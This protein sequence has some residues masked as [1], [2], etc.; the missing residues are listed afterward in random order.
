[1]SKSEEVLDQEGSDDVHQLSYKLLNLMDKEGYNAQIGLSGLTLTLIV[2]AKAI[3]IKKE[4]LLKA[5]QLTTDD[6]YGAGSRDM[7]N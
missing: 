5:V 1:M 3:G 6:I 2:S 7:V 4:A